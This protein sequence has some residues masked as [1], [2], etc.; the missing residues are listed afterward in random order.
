VQREVERSKQQVT[1]DARIFEH[2]M[3]SL[4]SLD[5]QSLVSVLRAYPA[6]LPR[7]LNAR[8]LIRTVLHGMHPETAKE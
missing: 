2:P 4:Q 3:Q 7:M 1:S 5:V 6:S 8:T